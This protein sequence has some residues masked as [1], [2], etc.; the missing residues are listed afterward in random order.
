VNPTLR[1][2]TLADIPAGLEFCRESGWNQTANDW[3]LLIEL[4]PHGALA[5]EVD[6]VVVG[7]VINVPYR[8]A[9]DWIA[10]MLVRESLRGQGIGRL[11]M[12]AA[13]DISSG[14]LGLDATDAGRKL[15]L[16]LGFEDDLTLS[17][18][19]CAAPPATGMP[20][21]ITAVAEADWPEIAAMDAKAF[22]ADRLRVLRWCQQTASEYAWAL[23]LDGGLTGYAFGRHGHN[24]EH[25]G[26]LVATSAE[27]ADQLLASCLAQAPQRPITIDVPDA[28]EAFARRLESFGFTKQRRFT[29]MTRGIWAGTSR[30]SEL[31][32]TAGPE[33]A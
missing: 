30:T 33:L 19:R 14:T 1:P 5:A 11:L 25:I 28:Q 22:G 13:L 8:P 17:R 4:A 26:P 27:S 2:M 16:T 32:A 29:R 24:S 9:F 7:T 3:K 6:G 15:Y 10:M 31:F 18:W 21:S 23:R 12:S 20:P